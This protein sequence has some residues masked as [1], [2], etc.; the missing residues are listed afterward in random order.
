MRRLS[1][2]LIV[3]LLAS[4]LVAQQSTPAQSDVK[5]YNESDNPPAQTQPA[6]PAQTAQPQSTTQASVAEAAKNALAKTI[7][8]SGAKQ[9]TDT[10]IDVKAGDKITLASEGTL[11]MPG[12]RETLANG[13][14]RGWKDL[15]R[16]LPV[17]DAGS[18]ALIGRFGESGQ[19][20]LVG[21]SRE[22]TAAVDGRLFLGV[23]QLA[24][25]SSDGA[26]DVKMAV[27]RATAKPQ[28]TTA[29]L[30]VSDKI[31]KDIPRRVEDLDGNK[32][33]LV[34]FLVIGPKEKLQQ[35]F[36]DAG[37]VLVDKTKG[38][39]VVNAVLLSLQKKAYLTMPMSELYMFGRSQDFGY[40]HAEPVQVVSTRHHL[41][42]WESPEKYE[43]QTL[44]VG[45]ATHD[46]GFEKDQRKPNAVTHK[47]DSEIDKEREFVQTSL[48]ATGGIA[49]SA[50][51]VPKDP[52]TEARTATGGE[53]KSDGRI[54]VLQLK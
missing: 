40:A 2:S 13:L 6:Q 39:A 38:E 30:R 5:E 12:A 32:G 1:F 42:L 27:A 44:W 53:I 31:L 50:F 16:A 24:S 25:E 47:I 33:D 26:Y 14:Q 51:V 11:V 4:P 3:I 46:I 9:W 34:N 10:G 54:L 8:V 41:R 18:G 23:N 37:W 45:A 19:P 52:L 29:T 21:T 49:A 22:I 35:T 15:L 43:G 28:A 20:F 7:A 36:Q 17:N 48:T